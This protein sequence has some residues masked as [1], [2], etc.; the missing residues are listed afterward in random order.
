MAGNIAFLL[1]YN[2]SERRKY[3]DAFFSN[4]GWE[5]VER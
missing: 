4:I 1:D 2:P 5:A 3:I